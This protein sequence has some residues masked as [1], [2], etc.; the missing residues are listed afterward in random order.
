[1]FGT[2]EQVCQLLAAEFPAEEPLA[3]LVWTRGNIEAFA[4]GWEIPVSREEVDSVLA[5]I[6]AMP[7][8]VLC[9]VSADSVA[10][11]L[12]TVKADMR[13]VTLPASLLARVVAVAEQAVWPEEWRLK[14]DGLPVPESVA[15]K[16]ADIAQV[17][18]R[19]KC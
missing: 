14:D 16:L 2:R 12:E 11:M 6:G 17:R 10:E 15:R 4:E 3:L 7:D 1:M 8:H 5:M 18:E 9:G 19:L 13:Q